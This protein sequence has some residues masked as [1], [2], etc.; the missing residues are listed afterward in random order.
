M[1]TIQK[2][3]KVRLACGK[4]EVMTKGGIGKTSLSTEMG[5]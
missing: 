1:S 4:D 2:G 5:D 3:A